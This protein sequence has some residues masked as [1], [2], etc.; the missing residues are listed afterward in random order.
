MLGAMDVIVTPRMRLRTWRESDLEAFAA[1]NADPAVMEH[2]PQRLNRDETRAMIAR[3]AGFLARNGYGL[4][5][6]EVPG[7]AEFIG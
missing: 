6:V 7:V 2:F 3:I 5:A 1:L 4:W